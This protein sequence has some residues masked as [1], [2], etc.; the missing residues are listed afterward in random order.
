M[1]PSEALSQYQFE[2][3]VDEVV[4]DEKRDAARYAFPV[5]D[6][7]LMLPVKTNAEVI[8]NASVFSVPNTPEW[9][10]GLVNQRGNLVPVFDLKQLFG[11]ESSIIRKSHMLIIDEGQ[12]S[13]CVL[14][15]ELPKSGRKM[16]R[17]SKTPPMPDCLSGLTSSSIG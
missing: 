2:G 17:L 15:D 8:E 4:V 7:W 13:A 16:Q 12:K 5:G 10:L 6:V 3:L 1:K 9:F 14:I 11:M